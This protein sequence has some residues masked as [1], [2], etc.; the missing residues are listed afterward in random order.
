MVPSSLSFGQHP[1]RFCLPGRPLWLAL[2]LPVLSGSL[3]GCQPSPPQNSQQIQRIE[4][5]LQQLEQRLN[6]LQ[7]TN[8][9]DPSAKVPVGPIQSITFRT[10]TTDD[11]L[12]IYWE[13]GT[14]SDLPCTKEQATWVCG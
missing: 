13:N 4:L 12:R 14:R 11:R 6:T 2:L 1:E 10:G 5:R 3:V 7:R 9:A 8:P